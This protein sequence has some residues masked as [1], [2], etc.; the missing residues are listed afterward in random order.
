MFPKPL[1][2]VNELTDHWLEKM[3]C[4]KL[5]S[6]VNLNSWSYKLPESK[7]GFLSEIFF[8][9]TNFSD[10]NKD[11]SCRLVF[12]ILPVSPEHLKLVKQ[13]NHANR[14]TKFYQ[15]IIQDE[16]VNILKKSD[17]KIYLPEIFFASID[18]E[19]DSCTIV[20]EDVG[21]FNYKMDLLKEGS[22]L[23]QTINIVRSIS[24]IH[25]AGIICNDIVK[26]KKEFQEEYELDPFFVPSLKQLSKKYSDY[27]WA[28]LFND[29]IPISK[30]VKSIKDRYPLFKTLIHGDLWTGNC[31]FNSNE[32]SV[33]IIDWQFCEYGNPVC[34][35][36][37]MFCMSCD[38][39]M[40]E[41]Q[42]D[43]ILKCYWD[44]FCAN[45][46][47]AHIA[48][49]VSYR[50]FEKSLQDHWMI[51]FLN[52]SC[53]FEQFVANNILTEER[54]IGVMNF[55]QKKNV[56]DKFIQDSKKC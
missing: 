29:M 51:G 21:Q 33:C 10:S 13:G 4:Q 53:S 30:Q 5:K 43:V 3:L 35:L 39:D 15:M 32:D 41:K 23:Q 49:P 50:E 38:E 26:D 27:S 31:L 2:N 40:L 7:Q 46:Q 11:E 44:S 16:F 24:V 52:L 48:P 42:L 45:L 19:G 34:D 6:K 56:F 55:L 54:M 28:P 47:I 18:D 36:A 25:A 8:V 12:K 37:S 20:M 17:P 9:T 22:S 1:T 14:E